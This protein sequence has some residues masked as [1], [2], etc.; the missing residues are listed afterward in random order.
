[1]ALLNN[2]IKSKC[3]GTGIEF[4]RHAKSRIDSITRA[5]ISVYGKSGIISILDFCICNVT[6]AVLKD[7]LCDLRKLGDEGVPSKA[8][9]WHKLLP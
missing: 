3:K 8:K 1:M 2:Y 4:G 6:R 5:S 7:D 9:S